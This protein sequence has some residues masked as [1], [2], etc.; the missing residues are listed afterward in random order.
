MFPRKE[1]IVPL[2]KLYPRSLE[3]IV[4]RTFRNKNVIHVQ[5][6]QVCHI[7]YWGWNEPIEKVGRQGSARERNPKKNWAKF[8]KQIFSL[9]RTI[10]EEIS[11]FQLLLESIQ[12]ENL[13]QDTY[14]V[15]MSLMKQHQKKRERIRSYKIDKLIKS[16]IEVGM[17]PVK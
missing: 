6:H 1:G 8:E 16:P 3:N 10:V 14:Q 12:R 13:H 2:N 11:N 4:Q 9:W 15:R 7:F 17:G 5:T